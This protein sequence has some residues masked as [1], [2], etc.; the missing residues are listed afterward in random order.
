MKITRAE[1][2]YILLIHE[3]DTLYLTVKAEDEIVELEGMKG[4]LYYSSECVDEEDIEASPKLTLKKMQDYAK[5]VFDEWNIEAERIEAIINDLT[6]WFKKYAISEAESK[7]N[8]IAELESWIEGRR[9]TIKGCVKRIDNCRHEISVYE[10]RIGYEVSQILKLNEDIEDIAKQIAE[11]KASLKGE[12]FVSV[13]PEYTGGGIYVFTGKLADGNFFMADTANYDVRILT[14]DPNEPTGEDC[15][16]IIERNI[17][18]VEWQEEHL[19][20]DLVPDE[21]VAFFKEILKWVEDH[22]PDGNYI[23]ADMDYFKN[24]LETLKGDWR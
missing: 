23:G 3:D 7:A 11:L 21:A 5:E 9:E 10:Q 14:E 15:L 24:E 13:D 18:S 2:D 22:K 19:V 16:G 4:Y 1:H 20:K 17:D 8:R 12:K 6:P